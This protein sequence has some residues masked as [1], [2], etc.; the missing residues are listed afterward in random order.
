MP[1]ITVLIP[2]RLEGRIIAAA[3]QSGITSNSFILQAITEKIQR[4]E[5]R[6]NFEDEAENRY[7]NLVATGKTLSWGDMRG[8]LESNVQLAKE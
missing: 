4:R 5:L 3:K 6:R 1:I 7:A 2:G 8:F